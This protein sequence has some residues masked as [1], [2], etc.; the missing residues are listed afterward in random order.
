MRDEG[1]RVDGQRIGE[2]SFPE[3]LSYPLSLGRGREPVRRA[4]SGIVP[5]GDKETAEASFAALVDRQGPMVLRVCRQILGKRTDARMRSR[6]RS[7]CWS[8]GPA[9]AKRDS[10]ASW[11][12][13]IA[14]PARRARTDAARRQVHSAGA[15][16]RRGSKTWPPRM[17]RS[18]AG[19]TC[20]TSSAGCRRSTGNRSCSVTCKAEH[21]GG[22]PA[23]DL[24]CLSFVPW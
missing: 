5:G 18:A 13:G 10:V 6:P 20:T 3:G 9:G 2:R 1:S 4:A 7:W 17:S 21:P 24:Q 23:A 22:R 19:R 16:R 15:R 11:L 14:L 12:Y 8:N